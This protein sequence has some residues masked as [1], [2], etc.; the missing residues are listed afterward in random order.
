MD[1]AMPPKT[2]L[3]C[4][5]DPP[6]PLRFGTSGLRALVREMTDLE[7]TINTRG[8]LRFLEQ[9]GDLSPGDSVAVA[10]DL[11]TV[12]P[13]TGLSSSPRI[14]RAVCQAIADH[15][16]EP[17]LCGPIPT[18]ALAYFAGASAAEG[19]AFPADRRPMA[20]IMVTGSHIPADRNG[21]KFYKPSGE[22]LKN[23]EGPILDA[24]ATIRQETYAISWENSRF[25]G[26]GM[27]RVVPVV[28]G[29]QAEAG[30]VYQQRYQCLFPSKQPL[31]GMRLVLYQHTAVGRDLLQELLE[32]LGAE[33]IPVGRSDRFIPVDTEDVRPEEEVRYRDWVLGHRADALVSTDGDGDRPLLVDETGAFHRGDVVGI[34]TA[35]YLHAQFCAVPIS[36]SDAIDRWAARARP[37]EN[38]RPIRVEKTRIGS[39]HVIGAMHKAV[40]SGQQAVV[41]WEANGGFL[42]ASPLTIGDGV[43]SPLATRDAVLPILAVLLTAASRRCTLSALFEALPQRF[44]AAGLLDGCPRDTSN[45]IMTACTPEGPSVVSIRF[46]GPCGDEVMPGGDADVARLSEEA[47]AQW[48]EVK[49]RLERFF[50]C[51]DGFDG[52]VRINTL[53]GIRLTFANRDIAHIRASGNAPQLRIYSVSDDRHRAAEIVAL[54]LCEPDGILP[55]L[56]RYVRSEAE[57]VS[58]CSRSLQNL[59]EVVAQA[60]GPSQAIA[61]VNGGDGPIV[62]RELQ[63]LR[64][65]LFRAD[66]LTDLFV[67]EEVT[68]RGQL[69]GL[70]DAITHWRRSQRTVD[71][72]RVAVG[73]MLPGKGTRLSPFTQRLH[74]I[75]PFLPMPIR[76]DRESPWL[77]GAAASLYSWTLVAHHLERMGFRG[78]AWKW[79]DEPQIPSNLL[80]SLDCDLSK[81]DAIRFGAR[82]AI[83]ADLAENKEWLSVDPHTSELRVQVRRRP[84]RA[85]L[86][87][88][89]AGDP[90]PPTHG[91][92][93][94]GSPAFSYHFLDALEAAFAGVA[95]WLDVDG[96][97]FEALTHPPDAWAAEVARDAAL[98]TLLQQCPDFYTRAQQVKEALEDCRGHPL[99]IKVIDFGNDLYWG[100][101]GQLSKVREVFSRLRDAGEHGRLA[102]LLACLEVSPDRFG[103]RIIGGP[104]AP[105]DGRIRDCVL[106]NSVVTA[107]EHLNCA[108]VVDS[109][110]GWARLAAGSVVLNSTVLK[111]T[112]AEE[113]MLFSSIS[114]A[115]KVPAH[116][117]HTSIPQAP[118][119]VARGLED[120]FED[121]RV[122]PGEAT[123]YARQQPRKPCSYK[124]K[125]MQMRQRL[126]GL[127]AIEKEIDQ[128]FRTPLMKRILQLSS[129]A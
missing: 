90:L 85:L 88:L 122:N 128:R 95:G 43:L 30:Q 1:D 27:F 54:G 10:H 118:M 111:V 78:M 100:D 66:G 102:R 23:D 29:P 35:A 20:G 9:Q 76:P 75:K 109:H 124:D 92:I 129:R 39:P 62:A 127:E 2:L 6:V 52:I 97:L 103:N 123:R 81:V 126:V 59:R 99:R 24:V 40:A 7:V 125:F 63:R 3:S 73:I 68:R 83:T 61:I 58:G 25:D 65:R 8:F 116:H 41:G 55:R 89:G 14:V 114:E 84:L 19:P 112:M 87:R 74:G 16:L 120:W 44:T 104:P 96:Y 108:V 17:I 119:D 33:V 47:Q 70:L 105:E 53:D 98:Q 50:G 11:R 101:I 72:E 94:I 13:T 15:H 5:E 69:L 46:Q 38:A 21:I 57:E 31:A 49:A 86:E 113:S 67:H 51:A 115:L 48:L 121:S 91:H 42:T 71:R 117:V 12:D 82:V 93:H 4:L 110:L 80:S 37:S 34:L 107:P 26:R 79:G 32:S 28:P 106:I 22:I 18:P 64:H 36:S 45:A 77:N 60:L 56:K